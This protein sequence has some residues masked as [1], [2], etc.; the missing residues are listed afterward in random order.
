MQLNNS[1]STANFNINAANT[2]ATNNST[3]EEYYSDIDDYNAQFQEYIPPP[4]SDS[5]IESSPEPIT[6]AGNWLE[7]INHPEYEIYSEFPHDIR[8]KGS[9]R[10]VNK[11]INN[12]GYWRVAL[13]G[14]HYLL[15]RL[16]AEQFV[17]NP[18][19]ARFTVIDHLNHN[20]TDYRVENLRWTSQ[21]H[22]SNNRSDQQFVQEISSDAIVVDSYNGWSFDGL[23]FHN[24]VF[25]MCNGINYAIRPRH[26][27]K[28]G[29]W[30]I[31]A[32]D[33]TG[34]RRTITYLKFK[35]EYDL[36]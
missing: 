15:H 30:C 13:N 23:Y 7:L 16:I 31:K 18:D 20:R 11:S 19:P 17:Q 14:K 12:K 10:V 33:T 26:Q 9:G 25:Y 24:D 1:T 4:E 27:T 22:N 35:K 29:Y 2:A 32:Y 36:I 6:P 3:I 21:K 34:V 5:D 28:A 8:K